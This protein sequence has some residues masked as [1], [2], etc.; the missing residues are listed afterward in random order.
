MSC[1]PM[2]ETC[3]P[4]SLASFFACGTAAMSCSTPTWPLVY[5]A[6]TSVAAAPAIVPPVARTTT[7]APLL[8]ELSANGLVVASV[9]ACAP[10]V[11]AVASRTNVSGTA[12]RDDMRGLLL[13][14]HDDDGAPRGHDDGGD[15][16]RNGVAQNG[17]LA[18]RQ[19]LDCAQRRST[20]ARSGA[21]TEQQHG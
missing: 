2:F 20:G 21:G 18:L 15:G 17:N 11:A 8:A 7:W 1:D 9:D 16:V 10:A 12:N 5:P 13:E 6:W 14:Q 4:V 3:S 19:V